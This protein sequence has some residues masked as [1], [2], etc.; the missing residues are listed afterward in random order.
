MDY[1]LDKTYVANQNPLLY[2]ILIVTVTRILFECMLNTFEQLLLYQELFE[3][4]DS[5]LSK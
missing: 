2:S 1:V 5:L 4:T 3:N